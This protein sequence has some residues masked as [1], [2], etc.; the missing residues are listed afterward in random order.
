MSA[1]TCP[2]CE[3]GS[4]RTLSELSRRGPS[5]QTETA[6]A[7]SGART[8]TVWRYQCNDCGRKFAHADDD[9]V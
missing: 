2:R 3:S 1:P 8:P 4:V 7:E 6:A 9:S 5:P